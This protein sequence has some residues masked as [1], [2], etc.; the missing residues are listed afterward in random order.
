MAEARMAI[1]GLGYA[2][3]GSDALDDWR[4]FGTGLVG[5]QAI[6]RGN[7]L[8]AFRMD[9]RKQRIVIDRA[10]GEGTRFFGW[11]VADATDLDALAARLE[12]A[13]VAVTSEPQALA[14]SRR[15][16]GL[17]SFSDPAGNR[18]EAFHGAEIDDAPF[19]PGR[20]ISGFRTGA[21]GLGHAV[22]TVENLVPVMSFYVD[23]LGFG[24]SDYI[25]KP[26][27]A[28]FFHV[29]AR[30]HSLALIETGS[31]GMHHLM[32]ELFSLDDVGQAYDIAQQEDRVNV[33]LGRHTNDLMTSFYARSP[34]A[35]MVE[36]GWGG[37]EIDPANW[38]PFEMHDGPSLWGHERVWLSPEDRAVA[39]EMRM[40]AA[41]E[42]KRAPVQVMEGNFKLMSGTCPWWDGVKDA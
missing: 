6:E 41:A 24:L 28:Y 39:R 21:L 15:V 2:G 33:T 38:T 14:D 20:S 8:L 5:L 11:E 18:L 25:E 32:V 30:H 22:L 16:R 34:S 36:C 26:F 37:R 7:A 42:G 3:F 1:L 9:D 4:Q 35:F 13:G 29:N 12:R 17:I 27:R 31:N 10:Q 23:V 40:R 19:R